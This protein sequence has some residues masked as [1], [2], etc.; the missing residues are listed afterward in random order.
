MTSGAI[1]MPEYVREA[2]L[3][4]RKAGYEAY[5]VGGCVRDSLLGNDPY[6]WDIAASALPDEM[7]A[8]FDG[9][10]ILETGLKHGTLTVFPRPE[11][12][13]VEITAFRVDGDYMDHRHPERVEFTRSIQEDLARRDFTIN[14]IAQG[15]DGLIDPFGGVSDLRNGWIRCVGE[16]ERRF[17]EDGLRILRGLRFAAVLGFSVEPGTA[18]A[19]EKK[20]KLLHCIAPERIFSE[21]K[22]LLCGKNAPYVL[23]KHRNVIC[24]IMPELT[25][26]YGFDQHNPFHCYDVW[27]HTLHALGNTPP[28]FSL[29]MAVLLHDAGKPYTFSQDSNGTGHFYGHTK[30]SA[31]L[32]ETLLSRLRA[33]SAA[34]E[35]IIFLVAR[36]DLSLLP[37][38]ILL[39]KRLQRFGEENIRD[40]FA[41]QKADVL[42]L[43][44]PEE[45]L[46]ELDEAK[47]VFE[48]ILKE[49]QCFTMKELMITG[50]DLKA[51]MAPGPDMGKL[52]SWLLNSVIEGVLKNDKDV[53]LRAARDW[54]KK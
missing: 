22:K 33:D 2:L 49:R 25:L 17:E 46:K 40:L 21:L 53:L 13:S 30:K 47:I 4:L 27:E 51:Y 11:A 36:H 26:M 1:R 5:P 23:R 34:K 42:A 32:A 10:R 37:D 38:E 52:L 24:E 7:K 15:E 3:R 9:C 18:A 50:E 8:V 54:L 20:R 45:K 19:M 31:E 35:R 28:L 16:P 12:P 44:G 41:I 48:K 14:A 43:A 39:K 6:D 29:R